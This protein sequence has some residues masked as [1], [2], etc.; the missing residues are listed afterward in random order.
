MHMRDGRIT[1]AFPQRAISSVATRSQI[2]RASIFGLRTLV[3]WPPRRPQAPPRVY[4]LHTEAR[5]GARGWRSVAAVD[6]NGPGAEPRCADVSPCCAD[7][8][9]RIRFGRRAL[10]AR[11]VLDARRAHDAAP[12]GAV[13][14]IALARVRLLL[15][16]APRVQPPGANAQ[17]SSGPHA[18]KVSRGLPRARPMPVC[19]SHG[20]ASARVP[21]R[22][23]AYSGLGKNT[24]LRAVYVP[25]L[26]CSVSLP[27]HGPCTSLER[28]PR[29]AQIG[30]S[31]VEIAHIGSNPGRRRPNMCPIWG[32]YGQHWPIWLGID[33]SSGCSRPM[34][35]RSRP[36]AA[37][38]GPESTHVARNRPSSTNLGLETDKFGR[39]RRVSGEAP[40]SDVKEAL[41]PMVRSSLPGA[42]APVVDGT[43]GGAGA[44]P[45]HPCRSRGGVRGR[46]GLA[47][48]IVQP[49][50][51][52]N[53]R[54]PSWPPRLVP[55]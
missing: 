53:P 49:S 43:T 7:R 52:S 34:L 16:R 28:R 32:K 9:P 24:E 27:E 2:S 22:D 55:L 19:A 18:T 23:E 30:S 33:P 44:L 41:H 4:P 46:Q 47:G 1:I 45:E 40:G 17:P 6:A 35:G 51:G 50:G 38:F 15:R 37:T 29:F 12:P 14:H 11:R 5:Q 36:T 48:W 42:K 3:V 21:A 39:G 10:S 20:Q 31:P 13:P 25:T 8:R 54:L 26:C